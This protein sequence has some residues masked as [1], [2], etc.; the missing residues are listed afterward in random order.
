M[1]KVYRSS[2][3]ISNINSRLFL[4]SSQT[5]SHNHFTAK[6]EIKPCASTNTQARP[7]H[8]I[9]SATTYVYIHN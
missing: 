6:Q 4:S 9:L 3:A 2:A 1:G 5:T 7:Y 8:T